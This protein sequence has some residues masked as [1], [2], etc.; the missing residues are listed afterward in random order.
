M[1][2]KKRDREEIRFSWWKN[3]KMIP[4]PPDG[5]TDEWLDL[6]EKAIKNNVLPKRF[7]N[8]LKKLL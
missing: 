7:M 1:F 4:R 2:I 6:F 3:N 5:T 8:E